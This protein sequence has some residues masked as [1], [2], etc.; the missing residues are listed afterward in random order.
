MEFVIGVL[1][2]FF[3]LFVALGAFVTVKAV[4]AVQRGVER[5]GTQVRRTVDETALRAKAVQPGP[6]GELA[7]TRLELRSSIDNTRRALEAGA[8]RDASLRE[9]MGLLDR[10]QEHAR[11]LDGEL[12]QLMDREPDKERV[13][14]RL[15]EARERVAHIKQSADSLRFAAQ[16]RARE[17]DAEGLSALREQIEI[18]SGALRHWQ[19]PDEERSALGKGDAASDARSSAASASSAGSD[20]AGAGS[21][22]TGSDPAGAGADAEGSAPGLPAGREGRTEGLAGPDGGAAGQ[23]RQGF[24]HFEKGRPRSAS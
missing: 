4:R 12:R 11:Q 3:V 17:Y 5:T 20:G 6:V 13:A 2:L 18:E 24:P 1:A 15:P 8:E 7:R 16:D 9:A 23:Q 22:G 14:E 10:L 19:R 21:A